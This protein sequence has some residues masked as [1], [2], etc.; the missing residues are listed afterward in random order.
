MGKKG[1]RQFTYRL[2]LLTTG[3]KT[4]M[5]LIFFLGLIAKLTFVAGECDFGFS[6]VDNFDWNKVGI[7]VLTRLFQQTAFR[8]AVGLK[9]H[10]WFH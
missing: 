7:F 6:N 4:N 8:T 9:F 5:L 3:I 10:L 1:Q 2:F